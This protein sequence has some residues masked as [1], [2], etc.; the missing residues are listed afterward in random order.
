[1]IAIANGVP[2]TPAEPGAVRIALVGDYSRSV[3]AHHAIPRAIALAA[4]DLGCPVA[5]DWVHTRALAEALGDRHLPAA[6]HPLAAY[7]AVWLVPG[8][9]YADTGAALN[10]ARYAREYRKPFLGTC[11][12]FQHAIVEYAELEW[13]VRDAAHAELDPY[14]PDPVIG[15]LECALLD[16]VETIHLTPDSR[17]GRLYRAGMIEEPYHCRYGLNPMYAKRF[18]AQGLHCAGYDDEGD[19]RVVELPASVHP[20]YVATLFQP[21]RAALDGVLPPL[22][23]GFVAAAALAHLKAARVTLPKPR[24]ERREAPARIAGIAVR[25]SNAAEMNPKQ[26]RIPELW[27]RFA[28]EDWTMRLERMAARG[29]VLAVYTDYRTD[30][31]GPYRLLIGREV[32]PRRRLSSKLEDAELRAGTHLVFPCRGPRPGAV[33]SGW[34]WI[35]NFFSPPDGSRPEGPHR[36]YTSDFEL[37]SAD[38]RVEI[39]VA[40]EG[41]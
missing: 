18:R 39:W 14:G 17:I 21:E 38:G 25:T 4:A 23:R 27:R 24:L 5:A 8:S 7:D 20:F 1:M 16:K 35:W 32:T 6:R 3:A 13:S 19:V 34:R 31:S 15:P 12:G 10:A 2:A 22:V 36:V 30:A 11:G 41:S 29:P 40:V 33:V 28:A 37:Y 26:A 9:P